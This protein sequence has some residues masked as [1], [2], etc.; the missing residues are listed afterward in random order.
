MI[1]KFSGAS[2]WADGLILFAVITFISRPVAVRLGTLG[3]QAT[4]LARA[5]DELKVRNALLAQFDEQA[6]G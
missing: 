2:L 1:C 3:M 4:V 6:I 5:L